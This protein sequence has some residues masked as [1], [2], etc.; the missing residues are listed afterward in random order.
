[1]EAALRNG[2]VLVILWAAAGA[3]AFAYG[4]HEGVTAAADRVAELKA[5]GGLVGAYGAG[6]VA[7]GVLPEA[8]KA[9]AGRIRRLDLAWLRLALF[10]AFVYGWISVFV[11]VFYLLLARTV[12]E[13]RDLGTILIKTA[14]DMLL[15]TPILSI[16]FA[17]GMFAWRGMGFRLSSLPGLFTWG[18]WKRYAWPVLPMCWTFWT[19]ALAI[20]Y[21]LPTKLQFSF[22]VILEAAWSVVFVFMATRDPET[23]AAF[24]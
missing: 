16:P 14:I 17:A 10:T 1:L 12:G 24:A 18:A 15:F 21:S 22:A 2:P 23:D 7:G 4:R 8:A 20:I 11:D 19:P 6:A 5:A 9:L 3:L 13:G